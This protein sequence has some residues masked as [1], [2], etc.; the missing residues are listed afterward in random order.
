LQKLSD[1]YYLRAIV[2]ATGSNAKATAKQF[3][4]DYA[5]TNYDDVLAD[6]AVDMVLICTRH[7]LHAPMAMEAARVG[8]AIF[9]E[10]PMALN[11]AELDELVE[12]LEET[13]VPFMVGFNRRFSPVARRVKEIV[14]GR[15]NPLMVL[16]RVNAGYLPPDH[17]TQTEEGGGRIVGEACH[18]FDLFNYWVEASVESVAAQAITPRTE[19]VLAGENVAATLKYA[20]GSLCTLLYVAMGAE[21]LGKEYIEVHCD[22]KTLVIEDFKELRLYG[23]KGKGWSSS[24]PN[25][26]HLQELVDFEKYA[27]E[28]VAEMISLDKMVSASRIA[29]IVDRTVHSVR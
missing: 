20:D 19:H 24:V 16:Y 11:Q 17:W 29:L 5:T 3:G 10:K 25:K 28:E 13:K 8:K 4:A 23:T 7:N 21:R 6:D 26:G 27:R 15:Q 1:L 18:M 9:L 12:V 22:G 14:S 2:S